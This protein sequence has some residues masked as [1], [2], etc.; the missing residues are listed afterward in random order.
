M[1]ISII[2][3]N[4]DPKRKKCVHLHNGQC[5]TMSALWEKYNRKVN[6]VTI[7]C[8]IRYIIYYKRILSSTETITY[9]GYCLVTFK[10]NEIMILDFS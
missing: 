10:W 6:K 4:L 3:I 9:F 2:Y 5:K 1:G 7:V 8:G